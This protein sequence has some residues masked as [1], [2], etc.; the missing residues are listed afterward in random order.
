M[1]AN[2]KLVLI[3]PPEVYDPRATISQ[4]ATIRAPSRHAHFASQVGVD[5]NG[6]A[7]KGAEAQARLAF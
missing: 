7:A 6:V 1:P 3:D 5:K 4:V 2:E